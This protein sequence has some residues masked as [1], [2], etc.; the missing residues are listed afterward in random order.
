MKTPRF[1]EMARRWADDVDVYIVFSRE[2]HARARGAAPLGEAADQLM[3]RDAD[4]DNAVTLAEFGGP[5]EMFEPFDVDGDGVVRSHE[6]L[7]ARKIVQFADVDAPTTMAERRA[8]ARRFRDEVPGA[9]PVLIDEL[10]NRAKRAY[11]AGPNSLHIIAPGGELSHVFDWASE[12]EAE[13]A[14][15]DLIGKRPAPLADA[16]VDW[17]P[18]DTDL[19]D[20]KASGRAL[21]VQFT[22]PGCK[23]CATM[24]S[25]TL[26][27]PSVAD[28]LAGYSRTVLSIEDDAVWALFEALDLAATPSFV[29]VDPQTRVVRSRSQG[30]SSPAEFAVFL[31]G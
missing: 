31:A 20:A 7:A 14:L 15:A 18:I 8:L 9:V 19:E 27:D 29:I 13:A 1:E 12:R 26:V 28:G 16:P 3:S 5:K 24:K 10:D 23:A 11:A 25:T 30:L 4:G 22:A 21:L 17:G 2:A 6:L